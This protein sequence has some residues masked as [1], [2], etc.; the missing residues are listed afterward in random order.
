MKNEQPIPFSLG[1][2]ARVREEPLRAVAGLA[3]ART[4]GAWRGRS[5]RRYVVCVRQLDGADRGRADVGKADLGG[6]DPTD[7]DLADADLGDAVLIAVARGQDGAG[8]VVAVASAGRLLA[9][10]RRRAWL[11]ALADRG[12][13][14]LHLHRLAASEAERRAIAA[15]LAPRRERAREAARR[16]GGDARGIRQRGADA[17]EVAENGSTENG[18]KTSGPTGSGPTASR[19]AATG[20]TASGSEAG[21]AVARSRLPDRVGDRVEPVLRRA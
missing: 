7:A 4:L 14:E 1:S 15:D 11:T 21:G 19:A 10:G 9:R 6:A 2:D 16:R 8:H 17:P 13:V 3:F 5:G 20:P 18:L 12:A